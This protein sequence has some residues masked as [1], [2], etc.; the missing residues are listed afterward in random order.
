MTTR[1][2]GHGFGLAAVKRLT[3]GMG[4]SISFESEVEKGTKFTIE[5]LIC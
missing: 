3:E 2:T 4:G 1:L 5:L